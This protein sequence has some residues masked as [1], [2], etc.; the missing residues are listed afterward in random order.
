MDSHRRNRHTGRTLVSRA[1]TRAVVRLFG[2]VAV[3]PFLGCN[4]GVQKPHDTLKAY[5]SAVKNHREERAYQLLSKRLRQRS[6]KRQFATNLEQAGPKTIEKLEHLRKKPTKLSYKA[7]LQLDSGD[8]ITVVKRQGE[9][10]IATDPFGFYSQRTPREALRSFIR[11]LERKRYEVLLRFAPRKW[12]RV[13]SVEDI[14]KF[15]SGENKKRTKRLIE[16]LRE[17]IDN[18]IEIDGDR[19]VMLYGDNERV[20]FVREEGVWKIKDFQ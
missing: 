16:K 12:R 14:R 18:R 19:A 2:I 15:Y 4:N 3:W 13:M 17:N 8:E 20:R 11:A 7:T 9:W 6:S 10:R 5:V 1:S